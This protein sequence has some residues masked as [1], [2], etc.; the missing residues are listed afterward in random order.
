MRMN[1]HDFFIS[2]ADADFFAYKQNKEQN[3]N[4]QYNSL[5]ERI[6]EMFS[7]RPHLV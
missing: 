7:K 2:F 6:G 1:R 4:T 3:Y 5:I